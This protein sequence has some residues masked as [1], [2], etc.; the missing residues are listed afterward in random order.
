MAYWT[1]FAAS[2][3]P[4][5]QGVPPWS[6]FTAASDQYQELGETVSTQAGYYPEAYDIALKV[7]GL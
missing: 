3:D 6:A 1:N 4:N 5:G 7:N 2:G